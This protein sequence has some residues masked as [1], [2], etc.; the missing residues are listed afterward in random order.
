MI[1]KVRALSLLPLLVPNLEHDLTTV[2]DY[3]IHS[4]RLTL[5][6]K[7]VTD[8]I[9]TTDSKAIA[10]LV[11]LTLSLSLPTLVI[12][13]LFTLASRQANEQAIFFCVDKKIQ[14]QGK[15][16]QYLYYTICGIT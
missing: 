10:G 12:V 6:V 14:R 1:C 2:K 3:C 15:N 8:A 4:V 11:A 9:L 7:G 5:R 13:F 16:P